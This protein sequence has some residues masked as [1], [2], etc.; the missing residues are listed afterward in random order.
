MLAHMKHESTVQAA[1]ARGLLKQRR[2][3]PRT[4]A[5]TLA[6]EQTHLVIQSNAL[7]L[8]GAQGKRAGLQKTGP[9][10]TSER[11]SRRNEHMSKLGK[12]QARLRVRA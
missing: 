4:D 6:H 8:Q 1:T 9:V 2:V 12:P 3:W 5:R 10:G 7:S 11:T